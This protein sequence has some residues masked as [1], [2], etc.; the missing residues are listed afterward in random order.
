[1]TTTDRVT[2]PAITL[3]DIENRL[4]SLETAV[5]QQRH[6]AGR[7][8][9]LSAV[10]AMTLVGGA[11]LAAMSPR[12]PVADVIQARRLEVVD[13]QNRLV[14]A[15]SA[16]EGGGQIDIWD[17]AGHNTLRLGNNDHGGDEAVWSRRGVTIAGVFA[18]EAGGEFSIWNPTGTRVARMFNEPAGGQIAVHDAHDKPQATL[19][20]LEAGGNL[21]VNNVRGAKVLD[22]GTGDDGAGRVA[23]LRADAGAPLLLASAASNGGR[24]DLRS[25]S[26]SAVASTM[27]DEHGAGAIVLGDPLG[28]PI[29]NA[30][31]NADGGML[32]LAGV[33]GRPVITAAS[34]RDAGGALAIDN[35]QG[36]RVFL[37]G[38]KPRGGLLTLMISVGNPVVVAG[39]G[40]NPRG[41]A[42][43]IKNGRGVAVI[44]AGA[45]TRT[46]VRS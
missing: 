18:T 23:L 31:S 44:S 3:A 25:T 14:F 43:S 16:A 21:T 6:A 36:R 30:G 13:G 32:S 41:G 11:T 19:A 20:A 9:M 40:D 15:A 12:S 27:V 5:A 17:P 22:A 34:V 33:D 42:I 2:S 37:V 39:Y 29:I 45:A 24:V 7:W 35:V 38:A 46:P 4:H 1:M 8:R 10:L 26:G 28:T